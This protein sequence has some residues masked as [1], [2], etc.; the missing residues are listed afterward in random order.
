MNQ[1]ERPGIIKPLPD[2]PN[3]VGQNSLHLKR[4]I[5]AILEM[6][7]PQA[8]EGDHETTAEI[9]HTGSRNSVAKELVRL[10]IYLEANNMIH[11]FKAI[12]GY[13]FTSSNMMHF[14]REMGFLTKANVDWLSSCT[15]PIG[16]GLL[17][18]LL[19]DSI[20]DKWSLDVLKWLVPSRFK[21]DQRVKLSRLYSAALYKS[22]FIWGYV[23]THAP[24]FYA[25]LLQLASLAGNINAVAFFLDLGAD[26]YETTDPRESSPLECAASLLQHTTA[27]N[28]ASLLL[29]KETGCSFQLRK[30]ALEGAF[31]LAIARVHTELITM[32]F[33]ERERLGDGTISSQHLNIAATHG[34]SDT[35]RL[36][37]S[38]APRGDD[39]SVL[40]PRDVLFSTL[41]GW[42]R[43]TLGAGWL[44]DKAKYLLELGAD[45]AVSVC[46]Q[47][48]DQSFILYWLIGHCRPK[49][50]E[51][52]ALQLTQLLRNYGCP[53]QKPKCRP[54]A[55]RPGSVLQAAIFKNLPRLV[56]YLL[57]W[58]AD[59]DHFQDDLEP[60]R[61]ECCKCYTQ[62]ET[63]FYGLQGR[64]PLLTAL[65]HRQIGIAKT[66]LRR[67]PNLILRGGEQKL[68]MK[69][70]DD[71]ELVMMLLQAGSAGV[72]G[73]EDF[74]E[75]AVSR[76]NQR[77]IELLLS[78]GNS[79]QIASIDSATML[80]AAL[81][82]G[83]HLKSYQ[84]LAACEYDSRA[85]FEAVFLS[86]TSEAHGIVHSLLG[87]RSVTSNDGFE[88][89]T[90]AYVAMRGDMHLLRILVKSLGSGPWLAEFPDVSAKD[91]MSLSNWVLEDSSNRSTH[92]LELA[93]WLDKKKKEN[94]ILTRLLE[95]GIPANGMEIRS[96]FNIGPETLKLFIST[97]AQLNSGEYLLYAMRY[98]MLEH[99]EVL[100]ESKLS[101]NRV[102]RERGMGPS[103]TPVQFAVECGSPE[104]LQML[105]RFDADLLYPAG[106]YDG[107]TCLQIAA[108]AGNIGLVRFLLHKGAK[109]NEKRSFLQGRTA[110][111]VAAEC[112]RLDVLKLLLLQ[113]ED[114]F[115]TPAERYQFIRATRL[116]EREGH[117]H[118]TEMLKEHIEWSS[119]DQRLFDE[120]QDGYLDF[121]HLDDMTQEILEDERRRPYFSLDHLREEV[122]KSEYSWDYIRRW[123]GEQ[124][125]QQSDQGDTDKTDCS[126]EEDDSIC[127]EDWISTGEHRDENDDVLELETGES[128]DLLP[129]DDDFLDTTIDGDRLLGSILDEQPADQTPPSLQGPIWSGIDRPLAPQAVRCQDTIPLWLRVSEDL[130]SRPVTEAM[131]EGFGTVESQREIVEISDTEDSACDDVVIHNG[132]QVE[133]HTPQFDWGFWDE[134][135]I[136]RELPALDI[137][138]EGME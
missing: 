71:S 30:E 69:C 116:A 53:L 58:G 104:M 112:G 105:L 109:V 36:L 132:L 99:V 68:A 16:Q 25:N 93:Y 84:H 24:R 15:D 40:L 81:I 60:Q 43:G 118:L 9:L 106:L 122:E 115:Q 35:I 28:I 14:L 18:R 79:L 121:I 63:S 135:G 22:E 19:E 103:R 96:Y 39:G 136:G 2:R 50:E 7:A 20:F 4:K 87:K 126:S 77:S 117:G 91:E 65:Y 100:C 101:L 46:M 62:V 130:A 66:L 74:L 76:R 72:D 5:R 78:I 134:D 52:T 8:H 23:N 97:G 6:T 98:H 12:T 89:R 120:L 48:C 108:G 131:D 59:I 107:A 37:A 55:Y 27:T 85:L 75:Q 57:D 124:P 127:F 49:D 73:W 26:P 11:R 123:I 119:D 129:V 125:C 29:S 94:T 32:L 92:I 138:Y 10:F 13:D 90:V 42:W 21:V 3:I 82:T 114:L 51:S 17:S 54:G 47:G 61:P 34:N 38:H 88:V 44:L 113:E 102:Y 83:D 1:L 95:V 56:D 64:S 80:R 33:L 41:D 70:G 45:P 86:H 111:E 133:G 31:K 110:I 128:T 137:G 67:K